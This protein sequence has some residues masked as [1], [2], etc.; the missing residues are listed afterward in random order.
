MIFFSVN[1]AGLLVFALL[2]DAAFGDPN[3]LW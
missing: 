2:L 1:T 3:W